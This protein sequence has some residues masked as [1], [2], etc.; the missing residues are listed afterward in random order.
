MRRRVGLRLVAVEA[1]GPRV[2]DD[3]RDKADHQHRDEHQD[4]QGHD[5]R[6]ALFA[7]AERLS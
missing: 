6:D 5:E 4:H 7:P 1:A 2:G 3:G